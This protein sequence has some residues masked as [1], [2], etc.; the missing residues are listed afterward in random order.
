MTPVVTEGVHPLGAG[1]DTLIWTA[2]TVEIS[3]AGIDALTPVVP[4]NIVVRLLPFHRTPEQGT[5]PLPITVRRIPEDPAAALF[6]MRELMTGTGSEAGVVSVKFEAAEVVVELDTVT[7]AVPAIPGKAVSEAEIVAVSCVA[8][9]NVVGRG[10][11]FQF[12]TSPFTKSVPFTI[13]GRSAVP[14][15]GVEDGTSPVM[16]GATIENAIPLDVPPPGVGVDTLTWAVPTEAISAAEIAALSCVAL[17]NVVGLPLPFHSTIEQGTKLLPVTFSVNPAAPAVALVCESVVITG[18]GSE[19]GDVMEKF[20]EVEVTADGKLETEI[21]TVVPGEAVSGAGIAAVSWVGLTNVVGRSDPF[22][23]TTDPLTKLV[24]FTVRVKPA[25][26]QYD[27]EDAEIEV[28]VGAETVN[29]APAD[30]P[31]TGP[32]VNKKT[33]VSPAARRS[34]AGTIALRYAGTVWVAGTYVVARLLFTLLPIACHCTTVHGRM[35]VPSTLSVNAGE[36]AAA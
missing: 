11:P 8:L 13:S 29:V 10:D 32:S 31:P 15:Y 12:T 33:V 34:P 21:G 4:T 22:Q 7:A 26:L 9:T 3:A 35:D 18:A 19:V 23:L 17:E 25:G 30:V 27:V 20:T 16:V 28:T 2:T 36:P 6:G 5:K 24:P 14:Q 1:V